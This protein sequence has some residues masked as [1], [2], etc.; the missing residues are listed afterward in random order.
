MKSIYR[1]RRRW[2]HKGK[3]NKNN[4]KKIKK[5]K[6]IWNKKGNINT[7]L[8]NNIDNKGSIL[9]INGVLNFFSA[10]RF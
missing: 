7:I 2:G 1:V 8:K 9:K 4:K 10:V 5:E 3:A 6:K